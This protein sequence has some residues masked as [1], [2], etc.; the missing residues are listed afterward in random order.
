MFPQE[1]APSEPRREKVLITVGGYNSSLLDQPMKGWWKK[2]RR[3]SSKHS[4]EAEEDA[5]KQA[6]QQAKVGPGRVAH[7]F[8]CGQFCFF[9]IT[10]SVGT[11]HWVCLSPNWVP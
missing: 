3:R 9:S 11:S 10:V 8:V 1:A 4:T 5:K 6:P 7:V 2:L